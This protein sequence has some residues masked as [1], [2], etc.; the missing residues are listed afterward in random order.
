M[1]RKAIV[2]I[3]LSLAL[4]TTTVSA[5][6]EMTSIEVTQNPVTLLVN[7]ELIEQD[8]FEHDGEI[9]IPLSALSYLENVTCETSP[10][11]KVVTISSDIVSSEL[12]EKISDNGSEHSFSEKAYKDAISYASDIMYLNLIKEYSPNYMALGFATYEAFTALFSGNLELAIDFY[13]ESIDMFNEAYSTYKEACDEFSPLL[14]EGSDFAYDIVVYANNK[15]LKKAHTMLSS[16][17][18]MLYAFQ[19]GYGED[20]HWIDFRDRYFDY[21]YERDVVK[22]VY[23]FLESAY[24]NLVY[25]VEEGKTLKEIISENFSELMGEEWCKDY[26]KEKSK[27]EKYEFKTKSL[28]VVK[29]MAN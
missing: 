22:T 13:N 19:E 10:K 6:S 9:Y 16:M 5:S 12:D 14:F 11:G 1:K 20:Q 21:N 25:E 4:L 18:N 24:S 3:A 23:I 8:F 17:G 7:E 26:K 27:Y 15:M 2:P 29:Y 28:P